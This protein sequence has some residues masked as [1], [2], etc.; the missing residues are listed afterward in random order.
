MKSEPQRAVLTI[1][2]GKPL[3]VDLASNLARSFKY[4]HKESNIRFV[5]A[6][7][8]AEFI[9]PDLRDIEVITLNPDQYGR[10]FSPKLYL[11]KL[12]P[13][14][15]TLFIDADCLCVG[16]L[17]A[18]F[19]SFDGHEISVIGDTV[20]DGECWGSV[21]D[22]CRACRIES[23]PRFVGGVYYL[24]K[25]QASSKVFEKARELELRY[26]EIGLSRLRGF[27]NEEPLIAIAMAIYGQ[28]PIADDGR[29]KADAMSFTFREDVNVLK[30]RAALFNKEGGPFPTRV[31]LTEAHPLIVHFNCL[32]AERHPYPREV[33][34]LEKVMAKGWP[35]WLA[36]VYACLS[37][38]TP[39]LL[40]EVFK[41]LFRPAYH[42]VF[43][44]RAVAVSKRI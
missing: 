20:S 35:E 33:I 27:A 11:D 18:V 6:T 12:A 23:L 5:L 41:D 14:D 21:V 44:V 40:T 37:S 34:K 39:K 38:S 26:D 8:K 13:A 16:S 2:T 15:K 42:R 32:F 28:S 24:E 3:Y 29:I 36:S 30:G 22:I 1:A 9:P 25:G 19:D 31:T 10:G 7:D 17:D 4:W 43:G